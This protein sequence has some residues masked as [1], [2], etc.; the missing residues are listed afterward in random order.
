MTGGGEFPGAALWER[1]ERLLHREANAIAMGHRELLAL[2]VD[3]RVER[4]ECLAGLRWLGEDPDGSIRLEC[5]ENLSKW[6]RGDSLRLRNDDGDAG[7]RIAYEAFDAE[8]RVLRVRR[9]RWDRAGS[10]DPARPLRLD[11]E[12][13]SV[14]EVALEAIRAVRFR[15]DPAAGA[16]RAVLEGRAHVKLDRD[17]EA[18]ARRALATAPCSELEETK[19]A[20]FVAAVARRPVALVQGPP[21]SGKTYLAALVVSALA[22]RGERVLVTAYTHRAVNNLLEMLAEADPLC[23]VVKVGAA[24][25]AEDLAGSRVRA[26]RRLADVPPPARGRPLVQGAVV[27]GLARIAAEAR[28]DRIVFDEAAQ[29][30]LA[31][32]PCGFAAGARYLLVGDHRQL[33]P[34]VQGDHDDELACRSVFEYL[35]AWHEPSLLR[36]TWRMNDGINAFPS[37]SFYDG[38]LEPHPVAAGRRFPLAAGGPFD[39]VLDPERPA[40]VATVHHEG[41]R[42]RCEPEARAV[43]DLV[44]DLLVRQGLRPADVAVVSPFRAQVR[45][46]R[47]LLR[48]ALGP[49]GIELPVVDTVERIQGQEREAVIVSLTASDPEHLAGEPAAFFFSPNRLNVTLTRART[50]VVLVASGHLFR[51]LPAEFEDLVNADLFK[52]LYRELPKV[53]LSARYLGTP[54]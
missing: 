20:A 8:A 5:P 53:D 11:P 46:I 38:K 12:P 31:F 30:P 33:G 37:R 19:R 28:F 48:R 47:T 52:R 43:A 9:D 45:E 26:V 1:L 3:D 22:R 23:D 24:H 34:I 18:Y 7:M 14:H 42:T 16:A 40:V 21:G 36:T 29:V 50:K 44:S 10:V 27:L 25:A 4:G 49:R 17:D 32:A 41:F 15:R 51:A 39:D 35:A 54:H 2:P 6:R 13:V